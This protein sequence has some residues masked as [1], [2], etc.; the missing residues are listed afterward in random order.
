[1]NGTRERWAGKWDERVDDVAA[2]D[3]EMGNM[4]CTDES[5]EVVG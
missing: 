1:M 3:L 4:C 2:G 5:R